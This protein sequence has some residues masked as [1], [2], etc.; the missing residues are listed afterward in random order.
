[1]F[2]FYFR[3]DWIGIRSRGNRISEIEI[4]VITFNLNL[5]NNVIPMG[6][7][8]ILKYL[9]KRINSLSDGIRFGLYFIPLVCLDRVF[10]VD[11]IF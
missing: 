3:P 8:G 7:E 10:G 5:S 2:S 1:M 6:C 11:S 4:K 9:L